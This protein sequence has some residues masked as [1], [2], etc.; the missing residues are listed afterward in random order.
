MSWLKK[1]TTK[2]NPWDISAQSLRNTHKNDIMNSRWHD[3]SISKLKLATIDRNTLKI[4]R[5]AIS[6]Q[7][8]PSQ[9]TKDLWVKLQVFTL[10]LTGHTAMEEPM[11]SHSAALDLGTQCSQ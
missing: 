10:D 2:T 3:H 4:R 9:W 8:R 1:S 5:P 6:Q 11:R 7:R